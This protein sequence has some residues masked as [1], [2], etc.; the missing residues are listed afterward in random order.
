MK[1][2]IESAHDTGRSFPGKGTNPDGSQQV[3]KVYEVVMGGKIY[4]CFSS[5]CLEKIGQEVEFE[6]T[7]SKDARYHDRVTLAKD[8]G[9]FQKSGKSWGGGGKSVT[10][11]VTSVK[12]MT[13][14]YV[15]DLAVRHM[16]IYDKHNDSALRVT[17]TSVLEMVKT[18]YKELL[19]LLELDKIQEAPKPAPQEAT[20]GV[21]AAHTLP[22][23]MIAI[24]EKKMKAKNFRAADMVDFAGMCSIELKYDKEHDSVIWDI[25]ETTAKE[26]INAL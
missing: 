6:V 15:K 26:L 23:A 25:D 16:E 17:W 21:S 20:G 11:I 24:L 7:P 18:G 5:R 1:A 8:G 3:V 22:P 10:E 2:K 4:D 19:P 14:S 9:G 13:L 12:T